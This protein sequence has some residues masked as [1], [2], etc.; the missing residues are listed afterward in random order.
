[1]P[2]ILPALVTILSL[3]L[4]FVF[5][6]NVGRARG[7]YGV[8]APATTG[9]PAFE[10]V[11]RVH[12]NTMESLVIYLPGLWLFAFYVSD[13]WAAALGV[14]W[15]VGRILFA[16]G[17]YADANKRA[18]GLVISMLTTVV[19]LLGALVGVGLTLFR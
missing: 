12:Y 14:V 18:P 9:N 13:L 3:L 19:L 7:K 1:M 2:H 4:F 5:G 8:E 11:F 17:Y 6:V 16:V 15:I 10:R